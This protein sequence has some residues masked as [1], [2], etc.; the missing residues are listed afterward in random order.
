MKKIGILTFY[1]NVKNYGALLQ[2]YA[3]VSAIHNQ[4]YNCEQVCVKIT[5]NSEKCRKRHFKIKNIPK[6]IKAL[7]PMIREKWFVY[8]T[9]NRNAAMRKFQHSI[10]HSEIVYNSNNLNESLKFYSSFITGSDQVWNLDRYRKE[11]FLGFVPENIYKFSYAA[12]MPNVNITDEKKEIVK[13]HLES[14]DAI[15]VREEETAEFLR[16]LTGKDVVQALDPTLLLDKSQWDDVCSDRM[17]DENYVFCYFLGESK[18]MRKEAK[19]FAK[20]VGCKIVTLPHLLKLRSEDMFFAHVNLYDVSPE[21]FISLIK[22]AKY[23]ITDSFHA[24]VFSTLYKTKFFVFDRTDAGV[25]SSRITSLLSL[26][27]NEERFCFGNRMNVDYM[28]KIKNKPVNETTEQFLKM[29]NRS[30]EFLKH[31][32]LN[33]GVKTGEN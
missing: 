22:Y 29:K 5:S 3:L 25:M 12:S 9:E 26:T 19:R 31:N 15:S 18:K 33:V 30:I 27:E 28:L 21:Q 2:A 6:Y 7:F 11:Y 16:N 10:P 1:Y 4:G 8:K 13:E 23:V 17:I 20:R 14:F 24:T 32:L